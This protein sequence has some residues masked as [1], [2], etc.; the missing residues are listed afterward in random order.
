MLARDVQIAMDAYTHTL[1]LH[2]P[3]PAPLYPLEWLTK[4]S[5]ISL[6]LFQDVAA[7]TSL[8]SEHCAGIIGHIEYQ[9]YHHSLLTIC[10]A[11]LLP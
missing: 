3:P 10:I 5:M 6:T 7:V 11:L 9:T 2:S 1:Q 4:R 8:N